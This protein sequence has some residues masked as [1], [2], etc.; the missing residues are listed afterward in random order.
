MAHKAMSGKSYTNKSQAKADDRKN[1]KMPTT[2][3]PMDM[4]HDPDDTEPTQEQDPT[5][6]GSAVASQ[7]GP[8]QSVSIEHAPEGSHVQTTHP[9]GHTEMSMH[10]TPDHAHKFAAAAAGANDSTLNTGMAQ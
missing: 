6:Q 9:D 7:H 8:A 4:S 2:Q 3:A 10:Q 1:A 5:A